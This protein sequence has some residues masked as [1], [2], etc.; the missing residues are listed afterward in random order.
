MVEVVI[1]Y[2][3]YSN[4]WG[5]TGQSANINIF[6]LISEYSLTKQIIHTNMNDQR[7]LVGWGKKHFFIIYDIDKIIGMAMVSDM[8]KI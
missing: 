7:F 2:Y 1:K 6:D 8:K 5:I 3:I 4:Q